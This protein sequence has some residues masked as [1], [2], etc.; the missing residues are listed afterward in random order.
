M[1]AQGAGSPHQRVPRAILADHLA[2]VCA[3]TELSVGVEIE[4]GS[5][6]ILV[7]GGCV[8]S[9]LAFGIQVH[10]QDAGPLGAFHVHPGNTLLETA[11]RHALLHQYLAANH[12]DDQAILVPGGDLVGLDED[13]FGVAREVAAKAQQVSLALDRGSSGSSRG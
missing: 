5:G 8:E 7:L 6:A 12:Q 11:V 4:D 10:V 13:R 9:D 1:Q 2:S 3:N